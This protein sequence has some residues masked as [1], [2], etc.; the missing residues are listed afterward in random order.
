MRKLFFMFFLAVMISSCSSCSKKRVVEDSAYLDYK[1]FE[2]VDEN[3]DL[4][5]P[6]TQK[7]YNFRFKIVRKTYL[8]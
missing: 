7:E 2:L 6:Q 1:D 5:E 8:V 3:E 4:I